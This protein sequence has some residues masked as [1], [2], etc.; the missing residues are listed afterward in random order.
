MWRHW[1]KENNYPLSIHFISLNAYV[2]IELNA[3]ALILA[4]LK[5]HYLK[6]P[7]MLTT[8]LMSSQPCEQ[9]FRAARSM[10]STFST[11]VNFSM[12]EILQRLHKLQSINDIMCELREYYLSLSSLPVFWELCYISSNLVLNS[13]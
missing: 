5:S 9:T 3:H 4:A 6:D 8:W 10:T 1:L 13:I 2:C 7:K 12:L 11:I